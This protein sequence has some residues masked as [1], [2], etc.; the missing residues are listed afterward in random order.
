VKRIS[1]CLI[2]RD[3]E[4]MLPGCLASV[5]GAVDEIVLVDTGSR[6]GTREIARAAGARV[7]ERPWDDDFAAPR[8]LALSHATGAFV[9]QLDADERLAPGAGDALRA[10]IR[11]PAFD[12]GFLWLHN[13]SRQD[14]PVADVLSGALRFGAPAQLPRLLR[15]APGLRYEGVIHESVVE[16]AA[17]RGSRFQRIEAHLVHLGYVPEVHRSRDKRERNLALLRRRAALEPDSIV[18]LAYLAAELLSNGDT[19]EAA[20]AA[21]RG[22][23]LLD[24]QPRH[25]PIRRL[26][27]ARAMAAVRRRDPQKVHES[28]DRAEKREGPNP[29]YDHLRGCALEI[30]AAGMDAGDPRRGEILSRA[31]V[32]YRR[33]LEAVRRGGFEQVMI[34]G[35]AEALT[36]LGGVLFLLGRPGEAREA[37]ARARAEG[38][39]DRV[40]LGEAEARIAA[41]DLGGALEVL[42]PALASHPEG[43]LLAAKAAARLG[44]VAD[45]R[46]F[47]E[48]ARA[49]GVRTT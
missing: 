15:R 43:W 12:V 11:R 29:D 20:G 41:G 19:D 38:A 3:E 49:L 8:N 46:L 39:G 47:L 17:A 23:A 40:R 14:A 2:A 42:Q 22:W 44:A 9:L 5:R 1:L 37:Y 33:S 13:A 7:L 34:A 24:R 28:V 16:W 6:D 10:A 48:K 18:P 32:A 45:A 27:V 4:Q 21:E 35:A 26:A 31:A 25:R 36:Q 30:E